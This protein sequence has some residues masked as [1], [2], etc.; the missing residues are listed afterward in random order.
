MSIVSFLANKYALKNKKQNWDPGTDYQELRQA[1][2][3]KMSSLPVPAGVKIKRASADGVPVEI[4]SP[5][6]IKP[7][8]HLFY[9]HGGGFN[10]GSFITSRSFIAYFCLRCHCEATVI[11]YRLAPENPYP[12]GI[13]D[14]LRAYQNYLFLG[15]DAKKTVFLGDGAGGG[16]VL[17][18]ALMLKDEGVPLPSSLVVYS[19]V[20]DL[21][22]PKPSHFDNS[23]TDAILNAD[24]LREANEVYVKNADNT[25]PYISPLLGNLKDLPPV[26]ISVSENEVLYD[27]SRL[28]AE[29]ANQAGVQVYYKARKHM[30]H[31]FPLLGFPESKLEI[32]LTLRFIK[33]NLRHPKEKKH[34]ENNQNSEI[35]L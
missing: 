22:S 29:K 18:L 7:L 17:S 35:Y 16:M 33:K 34:E 26:F 13:N 4:I 1:L 14:C 5:L 23:R 3:R 27:D 19:P 24:F 31:S 6:L 20:T 10:S 15:G 21:S 32:W 30:M 25:D 8:F 11:G 28:F 9:I 2:D 12:D